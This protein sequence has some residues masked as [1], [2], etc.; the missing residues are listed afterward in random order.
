MKRIVMTVGA[1]AMTASAAS[2]GGITRSGQSL[3]AL[4]EEGRYA[5]LSL[6]SVNPDVSGNDVAM[7]G[8]GSS[9]SVADRYS[10]LAFSYKYD[11]NEKLSF[12]MVLDQPFGADIEYA[13][14]SVALGGTI[15]KAEATALTGLLRYKFNDA[16]SVHGGARAQRSSANVTL[17]G[18]AY[19][20][21]NG[22]NVDLAQDTGF[23]YVVGVAYEKPEIALR[24]ALTYNSAITH[25]F[26]TVETLGGGVIGVT[27][28]EVDTPQS[29]SLD[30]QTGV[31]KDTLVFGQIRWEDWSAFKLDPATFTGLV[32]SGLIDLVDTTTYTLGVGRRFNENWSGSVSFSYEGKDDPLVSPLAP[33]D[34]KK[35]VTLAAV[36][37]KDNMKITTGINYT[38]LGDS[39]PET[40]TPDTARA[41][42]SGNTA[43]GI[44]VRVGFRF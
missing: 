8:G 31:A 10:Q 20:G 15:A 37:T 34:G 44:G 36:Y 28:T 27:P 26:D 3:G 30:F 38:K 14:S 7:F 41:D 21:L 4:F 40:G 23:G 29:V 42:F 5:E 12:A 22:Y 25:D 2:A 9:G 17:R 6:G 33:T 19:G 24:V 32:G 1:L 39:T 43:L 16:F 18:L 35:G 13:A 11:I